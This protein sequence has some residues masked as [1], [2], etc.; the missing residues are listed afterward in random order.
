MAA[1]NVAT[2]LY[3]VPAK[4]SFR[5]LQSHVGDAQKVDMLSS[6]STGAALECAAQALSRLVAMTCHCSETVSEGRG[7][8]GLVHLLA[9]VLGSLLVLVSPCGL[10]WAGC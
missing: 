7:T 2:L 3:R 6:A 10:R 5:R 8:L 4:S 9:R 1:A